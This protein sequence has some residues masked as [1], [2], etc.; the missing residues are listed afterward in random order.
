MSFFLFIFQL[1]LAVAVNGLSISSANPSSVLPAA[2]GVVHL[3]DSH[4][5]AA[6]AMVTKMKEEPMDVESLDNN[7]DE[8][9]SVCITPALQS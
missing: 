3:A 4:D 6:F 5:R 9:G 2:T 1:L 7:K 8:V